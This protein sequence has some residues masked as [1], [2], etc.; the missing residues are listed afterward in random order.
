MYRFFLSYGLVRVA[1]VCG[2]GRVRGGSTAGE[3]VGGC[4]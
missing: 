1:S 3:E 4:L 2:D